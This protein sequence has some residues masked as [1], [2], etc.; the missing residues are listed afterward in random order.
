MAALKVETFH[1]EDEKDA[2]E[3]D[4][5]AEA[6]RMTA[7]AERTYWATNSASSPNVGVRQSTRRSS[8]RQPVCY[9][10]P[11]RVGKKRVKTLVPPLDPVG[12]RFD[13]L[14]EAH[15]ER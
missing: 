8:R 6:V 14:P 9:T 12:E 13:T 11:T 2:D 15:G 7:T 10:Q 3:D 5:D 4:D 1:D